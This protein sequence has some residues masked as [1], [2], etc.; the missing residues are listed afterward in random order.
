MLILEKFVVAS[1]LLFK[2]NLLFNIA[3]LIT[4]ATTS[5]ELATRMQ[6]FV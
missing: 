1:S 3:H 4:I 6:S 2:L 5:S